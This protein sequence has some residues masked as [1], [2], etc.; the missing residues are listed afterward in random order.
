MRKQELTG[1]QLETLE[2]TLRKLKTEM[3]ELNSYIEN[4]Y[5]CPFGMDCSIQKMLN[6]LWRYRCT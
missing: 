1:K 3:C 5:S 6:D 2:Q 4:C